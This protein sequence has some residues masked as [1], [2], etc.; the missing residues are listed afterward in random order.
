MGTK[1]LVADDSGTMRK[2]IIRSLNALGFT[3]IVEAADG[4]QACS[5]FGEQ[6]FDMVLTDWNMPGKSG[7]EVVKAIRAAGSKIPV[8]L[9]TTEGEKSRVLEA[10]QAGV[11]DYLVKPFEAE[12]LRAKLEKHVNLAGA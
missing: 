12:A 6:G 7:L 4:C 2:I 10:I 5:L 11:S 3:D 9:I 1:I 8:V